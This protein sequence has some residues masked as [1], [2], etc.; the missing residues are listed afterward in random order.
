MKY[1]I[2]VRSD[3]FTG[4]SLTVVIPEEDLDK[5]ALC[6]IQKDKPGF[7][8]PFNVRRIDGY[9]EFTYRIEAHCKLQYIAG[10]YSAKEYSLIWAS[11][12]TPL[13]ECGDWF[14]KTY[15]FLL[16]AEYLYYDKNK[17]TVSYVYIP[18]IEDC[19]DHQDLKEMSAE[20]SKLIAVD[21]AVL[22]NMVLRAVMKDFLPKDFLM[23]LKKYPNGN[24][25]LAIGATA[26]Y[27]SA[28]SD[29]QA[30][31]L[32]PMESLS[33]PAVE[34]ILLAN[35]ESA[36]AKARHERVRAADSKPAVKTMQTQG[37]ARND[38]NDFIINMPAET[39]MKMTESVYKNSIE[40]DLYI[41]KQS[42]KRNGL[43][44]LFGKKRLHEPNKRGA[45]VYLPQAQN[46]QIPGIQTHN[47]PA[48][49]VHL[50]N[51]QAIDAQP[52]TA[53]PPTNTDSPLTALNSQLPQ[54]PLYTQPADDVTQ[55]IVPGGNGGKLW[56]V[57]S[58]L[59]PALID[60][61]MDQSE[62]FTIGRYDATV[63]RPQSNFEFERKTKAISRRHAAIERKEDIY[64]IVDLSSSAGTFVN[65]QKLPPNTPYQLSSGCRVSFGS[66]GADYVWEA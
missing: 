63:G 45:G 14:M 57:G 56:L 18:T 33:I 34:P 38:F 26:T 5:K 22:E 24:T 44:G 4:V 25:K 61:H 40:P 66:S 30:L 59:L 53:Q 27:S 8:L 13:I 20:L 11:V 60:V 47:A 64:T 58:I 51:V 49:N 12:L 16:D 41:E 19:S 28:I 31:S 1:D 39:Q 3:I 54:P 43:F 42:G 17:R 52:P 55:S 7:I 50:P 9:A 37:E 46:T 62:V 2:Q 48:S 65:G 21:D 32:T 15:S 29:V 10:D 6:A 35:A 36:E 23:T